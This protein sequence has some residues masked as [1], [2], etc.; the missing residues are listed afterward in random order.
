MKPFINGYR[1]KTKV[2]PK[3][4]ELRFRVA[5]WFVNIARMIH[6]DN[7]EVWLFYTQ[8]AIDQAV[9]GKSVIRIDP[10]IKE[11]NKDE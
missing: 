5:N 10:R 7:P 11:L 1:L 4:Y 6:P 9:Y 8:L 2:K 3:W